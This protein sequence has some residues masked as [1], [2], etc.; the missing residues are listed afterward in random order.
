MKKH[1]R[2]KSVRRTVLR[3]KFKKQ[4]WTESHNPHKNHY[5]EKCIALRVIC[6]FDL[7]CCQK[8]EYLLVLNLTTLATEICMWCGTVG[9]SIYRYRMSRMFGLI[10]RKLNSNLF[11]YVAAGWCGIWLTDHCRRTVTLC[12]C[13]PQIH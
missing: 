9:V 3:C 10:P 7:S 1:G 6:H 12:K 13:K 4:S 5:Y 2:F 8:V 11:T